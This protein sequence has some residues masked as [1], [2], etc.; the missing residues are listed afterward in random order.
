M[1]IILK[2]AKSFDTLTSVI[3]EIIHSIFPVTMAFI[4][5]FGKPCKNRF[6]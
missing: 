2:F 3:V 1:K 4:N 6:D 5:S